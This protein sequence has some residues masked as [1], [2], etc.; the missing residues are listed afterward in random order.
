MPVDLTFGQLVVAPDDIAP[1]GR[2]ASDGLCGRVHDVGEQDREQHAPAAG[3]LGTR[4]R[5][6]GLEV[7]RD[8]G[9][10]ADHP[11]IVSGRDLEDVA[12]PNLELGPVAHLGSEPAA[13]GHPDVMKL[14]RLGPGDRLHID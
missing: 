1:G 10:V 12:G 3:G 2:A 11:G 7:D 6:H 14:A 4:V 13:E 5:A 8:P 9:L